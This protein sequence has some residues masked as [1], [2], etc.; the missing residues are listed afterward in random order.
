MGGFAGWLLGVLKTAEE[1]LDKK[2]LN[3][4]TCLDRCSAVCV[5]STTGGGVDGVFFDEPSSVKRTFCL[6]DSE[7]ILIVC[8]QAHFSSVVTLRTVKMFRNKSE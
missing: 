4:A 1:P 2:C 3:R 6:L 7:G 8:L 5:Q